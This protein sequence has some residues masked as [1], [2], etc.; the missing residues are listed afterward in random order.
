MDQKQ[1]KMWK[2]A[3]FKYKLLRDWNLATFSREIEELTRHS[4]A[5]E[6]HNISEDVLKDSTDMNPTQI[7]QWKS[8]VER[9]E[10]LS[11]WGLDTLAYS[12]VQNGCGDISSWPTLSTTKQRKLF[13]MHPDKNR[14]KKWNAMIKQLLLEQR[15]KEERHQLLKKWNL[16]DFIDRFDDELPE[17]A[18]PRSWT[19][20]LT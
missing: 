14:I 12:M 1:L 10:L 13:G 5:S 3:M 15:L 6:W 9:Y 16:S 4:A 2:G 17:F 8:G 19:D 11:K 20:D 7:N 18:D